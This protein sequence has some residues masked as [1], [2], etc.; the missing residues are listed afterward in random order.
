[1]ILL[2][3]ILLVFL[4]GALRERA[5]FVHEGARPVGKAGAQEGGQRE[6]KGRRPLDV[7]VRGKYLLMEYDKSRGDVPHG[8][9][10]S[11]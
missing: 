6:R 7:I 3:L 1:M 10:D 11:G 4:P 5:V 2:V 9:K 8:K